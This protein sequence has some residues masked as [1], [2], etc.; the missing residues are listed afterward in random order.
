MFNMN[1]EPAY[2][3]SLFNIADRGFEKSEWV[4]RR[5]EVSV[6]YLEGEDVKYELFKGKDPIKAVNEKEFFDVFRFSIVKNP[7]RID[8]EY[9][10]KTFPPL[11]EDQLDIVYTDIE[12]E[13][14]L[15]GNNSI[16]IKDKV[17]GGLRSFKYYK[18]ALK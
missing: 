4:I 6:L 5:L 10:S 3:Y 8:N 14:I 17:F 12:W 1:N 18:K 2:K 7:E 13:E 16:Q 15:W 11:N 9:M